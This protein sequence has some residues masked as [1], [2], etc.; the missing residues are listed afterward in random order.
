M[1]RKRNKRTIVKAARGP[2]VPN[3]TWQIA[4]YP[5]KLYRTCPRRGSHVVIPSYSLPSG[6][7]CPSAVYTDSVKGNKAV[8]GIC[9]A[10]TIIK[11]RVN[12]KDSHDARWNHS[13][14][15]MRAWARLYKSGMTTDQMII[16]ITR[17]IR[18]YGN[19]HDVIS[20]DFKVAYNYMA[21]VINAMVIGIEPQLSCSCCKDSLRIRWHPSG[22]VYNVAYAQMLRIIF[23][24]LTRWYESLLIWVPT[25]NDHPHVKADLRDATMSLSDIR[26]VNI[27]SSG[28]YVNELDTAHLNV[29]SSIVVSG[30]QNMPEPYT[31]CHAQ[32]SPEHICAR[33][34]AC[35]IPGSKVAYKQHR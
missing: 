5:T 13:V 7:S 17:G 8:C 27:V 16:H 25:R 2:V 28:L 22:D 11:M 12:V 10:E 26:G 6:T 35:Y 18:G 33:C 20:D 31:A 3:T 14:M 30:W 34:D 32:T 24:I 21:S 19:D 15:G 4:S 29:S 23:T 9:Y 1:I